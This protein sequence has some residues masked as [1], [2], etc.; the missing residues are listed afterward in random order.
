MTEQTVG[1]LLT[2]LAAYA[3]VGLLFALAFVNF[4]A[5]RIDPDA[6]GGSW[7]FKL[8]VLPGVSAFWPLL[9]LRWMRGQSTPPAERNAHR[10]SAAE[11][12]A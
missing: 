1:L 6:R 12:E 11:R 4:G 8:A 3:G 5:Q 9:A 10:E 2:V 7:G